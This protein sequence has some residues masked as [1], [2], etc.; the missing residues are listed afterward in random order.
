MESKF[1]L[2]KIQPFISAGGSIGFPLQNESVETNALTNKMDIGILNNEYGY[3]GSAGLAFA[4]T[5]KRHLYL[6]YLYESATVRTDFTNKNIYNTT[7]HV[8]TRFSF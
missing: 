3:R 2:K 6:E 5:K 4:L 7:H 8:S 1:Q